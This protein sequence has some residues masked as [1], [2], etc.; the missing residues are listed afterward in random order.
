MAVP[1]STLPFHSVY[2][3][4]LTV[5]LI[6]HGSVK[7]ELYCAIYMDKAIVFFLSTWTAQENSSSWHLFF[8]LLRLKFWGCCGHIYLVLVRSLGYMSHCHWDNMFSF[9]ITTDATLQESPWV[10]RSLHLLPPWLS[11]RGTLSRCQYHCVRA[12][13]REPFFVGWLV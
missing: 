6:L 2:G 1:L 11:D 4:G 3:F 12:P 10:V 8:A 9:R 5:P 13:N 7:E